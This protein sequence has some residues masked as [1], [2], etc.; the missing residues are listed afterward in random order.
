MNIP[1]PEKLK[2]DNISSCEYLYNT[3]LKLWKAILKFSKNQQPL[4]NTLQKI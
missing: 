4:Y 1:K 2:S 3:L